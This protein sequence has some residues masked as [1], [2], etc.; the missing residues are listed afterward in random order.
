MKKSFILLSSLV[1]LLGFTQTAHSM[2]AWG[3]ATVYF[4]FDGDASPDLTHGITAGDS[5]SADIYIA[6]P[7]GD[8]PLF[9][10][11]LAGF[12]LNVFFD[13]TLATANTA[14]VAAPWAPLALPTTSPGSAWFQ[15]YFAPGLPTSPP[16]L[17]GSIGFT[18]TGA[19]LFELQLA[20]PS[21]DASFWSPVLMPVDPFITLQNSQV[22]AAPVPLPG[23]FWLLG[24]G[25]VGFLGLRRKSGSAS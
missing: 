22:T 23:A 25:L 8:D 1:L 16:V 4:D 7:P 10:G 3:P 11:G 9:G 19:G 13:P 6:G 18:S 15:G 17:L 21:P 14:S 20:F 24:S 5:F 2:L 12:E